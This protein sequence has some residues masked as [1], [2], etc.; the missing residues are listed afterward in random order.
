MVAEG[1]VVLIVTL[2]VLVY[3]P[4]A[5]LKAGVI[6]GGVIVYVAV[7][8]GLI[9]SP[10][11]MLIAWTFTTPATVIGPEYTCELVVGVEPSVV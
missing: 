9:E 7:P 10:L 6:A 11:A 3:V 4:A 1:V 5:G 2:C 8:T